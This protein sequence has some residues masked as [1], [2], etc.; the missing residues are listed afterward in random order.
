MRFNANTS[1]VDRNRWTLTGHINNNLE[2]QA[3]Q[4]TTTHNTK[5]TATTATAAVVAVAWTAPHQWQQQSKHAT[6]F[7]VSSPSTKRIK[8]RLFAELVPFF[9][10]L[11][12][13]WLCVYHSLSLFVLRLF[14]S[15][16]C[17]WCAFCVYKLVEAIQQLL[18]IL[19][20]IMVDA[21][22]VLL[23]LFFLFLVVIWYAWKCV[24]FVRCTHTQK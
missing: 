17:L 7:T 21:R 14:V 9:P 20:W 22:F 3:Q 18:I 15:I 24:G 13:V 8:W 23:F 5:N 2:K 12:C 1:D 11:M 16:F 6:A 10:S 4:K 19:N